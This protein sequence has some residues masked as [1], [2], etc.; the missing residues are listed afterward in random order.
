[1]KDIPKNIQEEQLEV[2][3]GP[4]DNTAHG[5]SDHFP[6]HLNGTTRD[7]G[8]GSPLIHV[9]HLCIQGRVHVLQCQD[10]FSAVH[11]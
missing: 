4:S 9:V 11:G 2:V 10:V 7:G 8:R 5:S 6:S 1:M 3:R